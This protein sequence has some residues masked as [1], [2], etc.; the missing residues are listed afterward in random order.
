MSTLEVASEAYAYFYPI[1]ENLKTL[2]FAAV[3]PHSTEY[4]GGTNHF[5]HATQLADWRS[6]A[7]VSPN[8]DTL[9]SLAWLDL[10]DQPLVLTLPSIP[11]DHIKVAGGVIFTC[12][13]FGV[14]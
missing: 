6:D 12:H 14:T 10:E 8:N 7:V 3:W 13:L 9:Y 4:Q 1:A 2:F 11:T 5:Q